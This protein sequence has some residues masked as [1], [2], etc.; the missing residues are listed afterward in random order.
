MKKLAAAGVNVVN[1]SPCRDD[2][3]AFLDPTWIAIRPNTDTAMM[4]AL[5]HTLIT[6]NLHDA[7]FL[8][9]YCEGFERVKPYLMGDTDGQPKDADWA[10]AITGL[11]ADVL[12]KLARQMASGRTM[13]SATWSLQRGDHGEQPFWALDPAR[14]CS[15]PYWKARRRLHVWLWLD[16]WH[17]QCTAF[18]S[19]TLDECGP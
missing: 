6:E 10:A 15:W 11:D 7:D 3:P 17:G 5:A 13:M 12:R 8:E 19:A 18:V 9:N 4:L 16:R 14:E 1:V 2:A